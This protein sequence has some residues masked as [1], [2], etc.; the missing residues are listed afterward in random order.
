MRVERA[1]MDAKPPT[2]MGLT[3]AS[4]PPV[5]IT[6]ASPNWMMRK[7]SPIAFAPEAHAVTVEFVGPLA[8]KRMLTSPVNMLM[9]IIGIKKGLILVAP[10]SIKTVCWFSS[11]SIPPIPEPITTPVL[12]PIARTS[13]FESWTA[14]C[15][16][17]MPYWVKRSIFFI[18]LFS[19]NAVAS[20]FFN[21]A[22]NLTS[23]PE[24]SNRV[25]RSM[26][27]LPANAF[28]QNSDAELPI[29]VTA[30]RPVTTT[31]R[32]FEFVEGDIKMKEL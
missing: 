5:I 4:A 13:K 6:S 7:A 16:A 29:G 1:R 27:L 10:F 18:S 20:K 11:V 28:V 14:I 26:P 30:P 17:A 25:M 31:R 24:A 2:E 22:A 15:A 32:R 12:S 19:P 8:P 9:I 21:S 3:G 23:W